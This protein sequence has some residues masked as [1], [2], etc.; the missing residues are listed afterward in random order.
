[1]WRGRGE[2]WKVSNSERRGRQGW[3][4]KDKVGKDRSPVGRYGPKKE[5]R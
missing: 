5:S 2:R 4:R 1:M 3:G